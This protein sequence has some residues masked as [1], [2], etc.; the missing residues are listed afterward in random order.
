M[1]ILIFT[2]LTDSHALCVKW[3][4]ER[5]GHEC[6]IAY[7]NSFIQHNRVTFAVSDR[8]QTF[9]LSGLRIP[10]E[11]YDVIWFRRFVSTSVPED[12]D[13][14]DLVP[15]ALEWRT[16]ERSLRFLAGMG[17]AFVVNPPEES[18]FAS[19]KPVQLKLAT[20][21][22]FSIPETIVSNDPRSIAAFLN[23]G[24]RSIYKSF[25]GPA[26]KEDGIGYEFSS[27]E[28]GSLRD[29]ED[30]ATLTPGIYQRYV[31]KAY[32]VRLVVMGLSLFA[33]RINSQS[34]PSAAFDW[35]QR[36]QYTRGI[37]ER[38]DLPAHVQDRVLRFMKAAGI[39]FGSFDFIVTPNNEWVFLEINTGGQFLWLEHDI[40]GLTLL[41]AFCAFLTSKDPE[42]RYVEGSARLKI[43]A[44]T[45]RFRSGAYEEPEGVPPFQHPYVVEEK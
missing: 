4:L 8:D 35:R 6:E 1:K 28:I 26:W 32:E 16:L 29:L 30:S 25:I 22:G 3:A 39:F 41:D 9:A 31:H 7:S 11:K 12:V 21:C 45:E 44:F 34:D 40:P 14:R 33:V 23:A 18:F 42:F 5:S 43:S 37:V 24:H 10:V 19:L 38:M 2:F 15:I 17:G 27:A 20:D 36:P 13:E